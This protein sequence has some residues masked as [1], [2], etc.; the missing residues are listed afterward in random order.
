MKNDTCTV[1]WE[2]MRSARKL[3][4]GHCF[5]EL[6][7]RRWLEQDSTCAICRVPLSLN[8]NHVLREDGGAV[9]EVDPT[10][11]YIVE[12]LYPQNSRLSRWWSQFLFSSF[13]DEQVCIDFML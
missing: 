2:S 9:E 7:L 12:A 4:C 10:M 6:C 5:H 13:S 11:Q 3:P 1:C 8:L